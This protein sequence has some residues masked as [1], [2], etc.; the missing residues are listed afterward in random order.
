MKPD[1]APCK[2]AARIAAVLAA[3][4]LIGSAPQGRDG[5]L[6][7]YGTMH[8]A[9]GQQHHQGRVALD[10][11]VVKAHFFGVAALEELEGEV[12]VFDS[13]VTA[14]GVTAEGHLEPIRGGD[15]RA[16]LLVGAYVPAWTEYAVEH[17][18]SAAD[19]DR[20][21]REAAASLGI[22]VRQPFMFTVEGE[23]SD[24]RMHVINGACP[25]HARLKKIELPPEQKPFE[26]EYAT[27]RGRL[28][29]VYASDAVG[30][31]TH[32]ATSTHVH[33]ILEDGI[34]EE[35]ATGHVE[36]VG[37]VAGAVLRFPTPGSG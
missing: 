3:G 23:L 14:T 37:L 12:T 32:P 36:R 26:G 1:P 27:V 33:L 35:K 18:V 17:D 29:G 11:L 13:D 19:F 10:S 31:L 8:E 28:V 6:I 5:A 20:V 2:H 21:V 25:M 4:V 30:K 9:I 22:D 24:V 16:T 15:L 7:Q 34:P